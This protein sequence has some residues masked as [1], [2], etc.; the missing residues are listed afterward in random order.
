MI[1]EWYTVQAPLKPT[2]DTLHGQEKKRR[3]EIS[4]VRDPHRPRQKKL[5]EMGLFRVDHFDPD[6]EVL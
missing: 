6:E 5:E 1:E 3:E 4:C 2:Q